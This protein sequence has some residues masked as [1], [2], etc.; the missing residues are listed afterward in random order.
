[1]EI[2]GRLAEDRMIENLMGKLKCS[3]GETR[4]NLEDLAQDLYIE[5]M[6]KDESL[7]QGLYDRGEIEYYVYRMIVNNIS[8]RTSPYYAKY[9]KTINV[10][11]TDDILFGAQEG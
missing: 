6:G 4:E 11:L 2:V 5:L 1:M 8:S 7:I 9:K 3:I 10:E